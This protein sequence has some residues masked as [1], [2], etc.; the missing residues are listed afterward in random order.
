[1][2]PKAPPRV[3]CFDLGGVLVRICR[4][5][6]EACGQA[7]LP[8]RN[9]DWLASEECL[10]R[11]RE[12]SDRYQLG[13]LDC[14][15]YYEVLSQALR[16]AYSAR[17]VESIHS[18]W[19]L[20][21]YP[22]ALELIRELNSTEGVSTACL[23]NTNHAHWQRLAGLDGRREYSTVP[24]LRHQLASHLLGCSKPD[25][26]IY[27]LA[28]ATFSEAGAVQ[29]EHI[30]FFDDLAG[31]VS[32]ARSAGWTAFLVDPAGDTAHQMREQLRGAGIRC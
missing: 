28:Q 4:S 30:I 3:V 26:R 7:R 17:E 14:S 8:S 13:Q 9:A 12:A 6:D 16:G 10:T 11:R 25:P 15:A 27:A 21:E 22:G 29:P 23:S 32:A 5:W 24:E 2:A 31:N 20:D 18:A 19:T 1:M